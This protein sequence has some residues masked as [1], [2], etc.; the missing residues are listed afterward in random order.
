MIYCLSDRE[1][2]L[3]N[4]VYGNRDSSWNSLSKP[5]PAECSVGTAWLVLSWRCLMLVRRD[6]CMVSPALVI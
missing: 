3:K 6:N 4:E 1:I 2:I 5:S